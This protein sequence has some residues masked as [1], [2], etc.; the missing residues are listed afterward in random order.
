MVDSMDKEIDA[1][2]I[3]EQVAKGKKIKRYRQWNG[4]LFR[5]YGDIA[6]SNRKV[7]RLNR[8]QHKERR[9]HEKIWH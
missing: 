1:V 9:R 4:L 6:S 2:Y 3:H 5:R 7:F 8:R